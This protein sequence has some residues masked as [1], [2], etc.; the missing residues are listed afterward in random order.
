MMGREVIHVI[1]SDAKTWL[2]DPLPYQYQSVVCFICSELST[3]FNIFS[4]S[5]EFVCLCYRNKT[6]HQI[7]SLDFNV[8]DSL[9]TKLERSV[10]VPRRNGENICMC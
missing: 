7:I 10:S 2:S 8:L 3:N 1:T 6:A 5:M 9:N 4:T